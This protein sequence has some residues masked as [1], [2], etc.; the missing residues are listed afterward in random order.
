MASFAL[1]RIAAPWGSRRLECGGF[2]IHRLWFRYKVV[3]F[4]IHFPVLGTF[5]QLPCCLP[6]IQLRSCFA[7]LM[8]SST[9]SSSSFLASFSKG[10]WATWIDPGPSSSGSPQLVSCGMSVVNLA[11]MVGRPST[12]RRRTKGISSV[13][14]TSASPRAAS[15]NAARTGAESPHQPHQHLRLGLVGDHVGRVAAVN[16]ADVERAG[17]DVFNRRQR[18]GEHL[19]QHLHQLVHGA[20]AQLGIGR[21]RHLAGGLEDRAQGALGGQRQAIVGGLAVDEEAAALGR[22][23]GRLGAGRVAL[24]AGDK[25]QPNPESRRAQRL[26]GGDLGGDDSLGVGDP[27]PIHET[28]RPR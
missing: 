17:A 12:A 24:F 7:T 27:A 22:Q 21:V 13:K 6:S 25:Q 15:I 18:Q 8:Y 1:C 23:V 5:M 16:L 26:G 2:G 14:S 9:A 19:A 28:P 20:L 4:Q 10:V 3:P 11:I